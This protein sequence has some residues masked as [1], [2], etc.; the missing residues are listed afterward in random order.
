VKVK[1]TDEV[2]TLTVTATG[3][4]FKLSVTLNGSTETTA[5]I[6]VVGLSAA[7]IRRRSS[8]WA[9]SNPAM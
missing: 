9:T 2:Q 1:G 3:G 6:A 5:N 8:R 7:N 4:N